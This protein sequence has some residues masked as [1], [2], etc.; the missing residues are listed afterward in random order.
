MERLDSGP[1]FLSQNERKA[2][3]VSE[4]QDA[5]ETD[6]TS[7]AKLNEEQKDALI[8]YDLASERYIL[9]TLEG[10]KM[11]SAEELFSKISKTSKFMQMD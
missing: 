3:S 10:Y 8:T 5:V 7:E 4:D 2:E 1:M 9:K 6:T 11:T